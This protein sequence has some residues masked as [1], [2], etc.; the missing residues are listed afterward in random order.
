M[1]AATEAAKHGEEQDEAGH[2]VAAAPAHGSALKA[3]ETA[4]PASAAASEC[5]RHTVAAAPVQGAALKATGTAP[6]AS[7]AASMG[8]ATEA[9]KH[10]EEGEGTMMLDTTWQRHQ[11][12]AR[13]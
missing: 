11:C 13:R 12:S 7:A 4:P 9:A 1:G 10:E 2:T 3:T 6:P 8:A 5:V